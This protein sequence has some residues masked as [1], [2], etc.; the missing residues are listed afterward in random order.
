MAEPD[1]NTVDA[2]GAARLLADAGS[3]LVIGH[4]NPDADAI[5]SANS[6]AL[7][8]QARGQRAA[9]TA[10]SAQQLPQ[11]LS[12]LPGAG[13]FVSAAQALAGTFD[14]VVTVD[15]GSAD[16]LGSMQPVLEGPAPVLVIDHH[17]SN[18]RYGT[19]HLIDD[20]ADSAAQIVLQ[21]IEALG[22]QLTEAISA[23]VYA[24]LCTDTGHFRRASA[25]SYQLA[26]R[27]VSTGI[28]TEAIVRPLTDEHPFGWL[29]ML[30]VVLGR[31][32]LYP[33]A[34]GGAGL[35]STWI[36][37]ADLAGLRPEEAD[38]VIDIVRTARDA[39][40]TCV[41]KQ[42]AQDTWNVSMRAR[43]PYRVGAL[44]QRLG[45]G[46]HH[47]AAGFTWFGDVHAAIDAVRAGLDEDA[48]T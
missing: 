11:S 45:G 28:D 34:L 23:N 39:A 18:T 40:V 21:V 30:S 32:R 37:T 48:A 38:S 16:R 27:L 47:T 13:L 1:V 5:G 2:A 7:T 41:V 19:F 3:V 8:L 9:V 20:Q 35:V 17:V 26:S 43:K 12:T 4:M 25:A 44:A 42:T 6:L 24:A 31:A 15:T 29:E 46:G 22:G 14:V 33:D 10:G 36:T